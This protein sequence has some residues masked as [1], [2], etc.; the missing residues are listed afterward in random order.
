MIARLSRLRQF[1]LAYAWAKLRLKLKRQ[2]EKT[3]Y[4]TW[5]SLFDRKKDFFLKKEAKTFL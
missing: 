5:I 3:D 1:G 4:A 2:N